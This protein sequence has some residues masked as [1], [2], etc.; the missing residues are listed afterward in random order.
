VER[1]TGTV[2]APADA[3]DIRQADDLRLAL[4]E[5]E[6]AVA[7]LRGVGPAGVLK[8][9]RLLD[10]IEEAIPRLESMYG[11]DLKPE[12]TRL[13]TLENITRSQTTRLVREAGASTLAR[14]RMELDPPEEHW[15]W[16]LDRSLAEQRQD[17]LRRWSLRGVV[18]A[19]VL[20]LGLLAYNHFLAPSPEEQA[21][22]TRTSAGEGYLVQGDY[23]AALPEFEA[24][25]ALNPK[26]L[27]ARLQLAVVYEQLGRAEDAAQQLARA[28][29][30]ADSEADFYASLSL[31]YYRVGVGGMDWAVE[32][33]Y[34]TAMD[35]VE[36]DDGSA[37]AHF[38]LASAYE[39]QGETA[40]AID[41]FEF[42]SNISQD[43]SLTVMARMR[44]GMLMQSPGDMMGGFGGGMF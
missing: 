6:L 8:Y 21:F 29:D 24:A 30:L 25:A 27:G 28:R 31:V 36:A 34:E 17:S 13:E 38:A 22:S 5:A 42:A 33:A 10:D 41:E 35:A 26:D 40:K 37:L 11:V 2:D 44:M 23:E 39:L 4:R 32:K 3:G 16:Y 18:L 1:A 20:L 12:R 9:L 7:S 15:W 43:A 14:A 19:T